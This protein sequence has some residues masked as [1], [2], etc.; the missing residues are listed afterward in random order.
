MEQQD[1][2]VTCKRCGS[3]ICLEQHLGEGTTVWFDPKCGFTTSTVLTE[4]S[5]ATMTA[6]ETY[7]ELYKDLMFVDEDKRVWLPA[8]VTVPN[9]GMVFVDGT[10]KDDWKWASVKSTEL[11]K[12]DK[13]SKRF[14]KGQTHK[15][16]M[17][18]IKHFSQDQFLEA[19]A[20]SNVI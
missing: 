13:K 10:S 18:T 1:R 14:P 17:S 4:G 12:E 9:V 16:D 20:E 7:P 19:M 2:L 11:T 5:K 3:T 15:M 8:N 6:I